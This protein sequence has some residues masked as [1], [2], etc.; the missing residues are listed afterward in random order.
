MYQ[1]QA[2]DAVIHVFRVCHVDKDETTFLLVVPFGKEGAGGV[3]CALDL[4]LESS[5]ELHIA[6]RFLCLN[7]GYFQN[8]F[9]E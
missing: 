3:D 1:P 4:S 8:T 6:A 9:C 5:A 2:G 7:A